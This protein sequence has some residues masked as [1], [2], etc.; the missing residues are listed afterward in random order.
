MSWASV[1][2]LCRTKLGAR[3]EGFKD[4]DSPSGLAAVVPFSSWA[5]R[6]LALL[7][8]HRAALGQVGADQTPDFGGQRAVFAGGDRLQRP[9]LS[10]W[11][12][13]RYLPPL[14]VLRHR[15]G[16]VSASADRLHTVHPTPRA[17]CVELPDPSRR[18]TVPE[19]TYVSLRVPKDIYDA[20]K[21]VA[22][23]EERSVSATARRALKRFLAEQDE[24]V[25]AAAA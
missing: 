18:R 4:A 12:S 24:P 6:H 1:P 22:E 23:R 8:G 14:F 20:V 13:N 9:H 7:R 10:G 16:K 11:E 19:Q 15:S 25:G 17:Y 5:P 3:A 2:R 21:Q